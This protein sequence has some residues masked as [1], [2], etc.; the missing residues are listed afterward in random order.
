MRRNRQILKQASF[1]WRGSAFEFWSNAWNISFRQRLSTLVKAHAIKFLIAQ[2]QVQS[3][4]FQ[5]KKEKHLASGL[6]LI[7]HSFYINELYD[8]FLF[9]LFTRAAQLYAEPLFWAEHF[10]RGGY[11]GRSKMCAFPRGMV[12]WA[13][14]NVILPLKYKSRSPHG[15]GYFVWKECW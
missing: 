3:L 14:C 4:F 11:E 7:R 13:Q 8:D 10:R 2:E 12:A 5:T 6:C 1:F 15:S 9:F